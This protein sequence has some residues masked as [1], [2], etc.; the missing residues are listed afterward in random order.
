MIQWLDLLMKRENETVQIVLEWKLEEK[1]PKNSW[2][3]LFNCV[4]IE[5]FVLENREDCY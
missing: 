5:N 3:D 4:L 1:R 2:I